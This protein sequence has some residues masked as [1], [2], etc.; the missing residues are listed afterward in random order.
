MIQTKLLLIEYAVVNN[1]SY[2]GTKLHAIRSIKNLLTQID[3][4]SEVVP[5]EN[6][7]K[8][9]EFLVSLKGSLLSREEESLV[10]E[11]MTI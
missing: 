7:N 9:K 2:D 3:F 8:L 11:I 10:E 1:D 6:E 4:N 5:I